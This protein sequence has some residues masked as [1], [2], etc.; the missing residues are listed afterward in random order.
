V[1][2]LRENR[3]RLETIADEEAD[4]KAVHPTYVTPPIPPFRP[5]MSPMSPSLASR[6]PASMPQIDEESEVEYL[7]QQFGSMEINTP[8]AIPV[9]PPRQVRHGRN[10]SCISGF[11]GIGHRAWGDDE[12]RPS[13]A[14]TNNP[15]INININ[16]NISTPA[17]S[18][19]AP[20]LPIPNTA[21][22][23]QTANAQSIPRA[24]TPSRDAL[25]ALCVSLDDAEQLLLATFGRTYTQGG[26]EVGAARH[27]IDRLQTGGR[28]VP[29]AV[30]L[31][32]SMTKGA[33]KTVA[34][35]LSGNAVQIAADDKNRPHRQA[36][37]RR[38]E[39]ERE[40]KRQKKAQEAADAVIARELQGQLN[41]MLSSCTQPE[42]TDSRTCRMFT[43]QC[44]NAAALQQA[45]E[46]AADDRTARQGRG[47]QRSRS[48]SQYQAHQ[49]WDRESRPY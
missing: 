7:G 17:P 30:M 21:I 46:E 23:N 25:H 47:H 36:K 24:P 31:A 39:Q 12:P 45:R 29:E 43:E 32:E 41:P 33:L 28:I 1:K 9:P 26:N 2:A 22:C 11:Q 48:D 37:L 6:A 8:R 34:D 16:I 20:Q 5:S 18:A 44:D 14:N 27:Y 3:N 15:S 13:S 40:E 38:E 10:A 4:A 42:D 19:P 49:Y 35:A